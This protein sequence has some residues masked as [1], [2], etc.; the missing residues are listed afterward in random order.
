MTSA[1]PR[2]E[3]ENSCHTPSNFPAGFAQ[4]TVTV[5]EAGEVAHRIV[6]ITVN[7][8][9]TNGSQ[10]GFAV[11]H[12]YPFDKTAR[13]WDMGYTIHAHG[14]RHWR[15]AADTS[16]GRYHTATTVFHSTLLS[17]SAP[18]DA[19]TAAYS[20]IIARPIVHL[21]AMPALQRDCSLQ[22]TGFVTTAWARQR[23]RRDNLTD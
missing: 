18:P 6:F 16:S 3:I 17:R 2:F 22:K 21:I 9:T 15:H 13:L 7:I 5:H 20:A 23:R 11:R 1:S 10:C 14:S 4:H 12:R 19:D 8:A